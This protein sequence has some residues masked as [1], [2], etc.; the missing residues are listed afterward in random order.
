MITSILITAIS[1]LR[2]RAPDSPEADGEK[3][4]E[5]ARWVDYSSANV[6]RKR[7]PFSALE[8]RISRMGVDALHKSAKRSLIETMTTKRLRWPVKLFGDGRVREIALFCPILLCIRERKAIIVNRK[9]VNFNAYAHTH[10]HTRHVAR[11]TSV[12][13]RACTTARFLFV[14][15][16]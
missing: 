6:V 7:S 2:G 13:K 4:L 8:N 1:R 14:Y 12:D 3:E 15:L 11:V 5:S 16:T 10:T 9:I